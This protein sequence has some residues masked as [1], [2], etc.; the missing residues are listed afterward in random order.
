MQN[1]ARQSSAIHILGDS[2]FEN[3]SFNVRQTL[4]LIP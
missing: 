4:Q 1:T 2:G 3:I